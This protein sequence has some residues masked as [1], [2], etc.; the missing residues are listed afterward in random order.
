VAPDGL[1]VLGRFSEPALVILVSLSDGPK[2]GHAMVEDIATLTGA[3]LPPTHI[4]RHR[5]HRSLIAPLPGWDSE[6]NGL[7]CRSQPQF[8]LIAA[9]A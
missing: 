1:A 4:R 6:P 9:Q 7:F 8:S 5:P 2:D 3:R